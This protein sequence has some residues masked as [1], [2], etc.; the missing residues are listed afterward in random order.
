MAHSMPIT[1]TMSPAR[2]RV[3]VFL[4][5]GVDAEDPADPRPLPLP[6]VE[7]EAPLGQRPLVDADERDLAERLLDELER[8]GHQRRV[9]VGRQRH[10]GPAVGVVLGEDL[11]VERA[12]QIAAD[13]VQERLNPLVAVGRADHHRA[14]LL[15]DRPLADRLVDQLD[16]DLGLFEQAAP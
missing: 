12:G 10:L 4:L 11:A 9:G 1:A 14:E 2:G 6:R 15:G 7:V 8:H 13:G 16:R 5:V 3:D